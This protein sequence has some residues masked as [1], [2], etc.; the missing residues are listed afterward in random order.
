MR[1]GEVVEMVVS[2]TDIR[3]GRPLP[4]VPASSVQINDAVALCEDAEGGMVF[5]WGMA[6]FSWSAD[7]LCGR[8]L[9]AV[10]LIALGAAKVMEV[11]AGFGAE[12]TTLWRWC[13]AYCEGGVEALAGLPKGPK[14]PSKLTE[15]K[16]A[17][18]VALRAAGKTIAETAEVAGV[19]ARSIASAAVIKGEL[20]PPRAGTST[21]LVVARS[22]QLVPLARPAPRRVE[23]Q[24]ARA[25]LLDG[26]EAVFTDGASV[27]L[28]GVLCI[29]PALA[30]TGIVDAFKAVWPEARAAFYSLTQLVCSFAFATLLGA[31]RAERA[32]RI[33]PTA[34]GRLLGVDRGPTAHTLRRRL[35]DLAGLGRSDKLWAALAAHHLRRDGLPEG[36]VYLDGHVRAYHGNADLAKAHLARMRIA[37]AATEDLWLNDALGKAVLVWT[38]E[39]GSGLV[40]QLRRAVGEVRAEL[41]DEGPMTVVFDRGGWSPATFAQLHREGADILTYRKSP[42]P[43]EPASAFKACEVLDEWGHPETYL[44]SDR[45]VRVYYDKRRHYFSCRQI[46]RLDPRTGHQTQ[47]VTTRRDLGAGQLAQ[48]MFGR[49]GASE[50]FFRYSRARFELDGLDSYAKIADDPTRLVTNPAKRAAAK[51]IKE[52]K[53]SLAQA[54][55][56]QGRAALE[57]IHANEELKTAFA[58]A[59]KHIENLKAESKAIPAKVPLG[60]LHPNGERLDPERKRVCDA[61][62]ISAYNA[63]TTLARMLRPHYK[64]AEDEARTLLRE[65]YT[66]PA[67]MQVVGDR[68]EIRIEPLSAPHRTKALAALCEELTASQT[69][70]PGTSLTLAYSVK[71][72]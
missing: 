20:A 68:L 50:N 29:L 23:R 59:T 70:Y 62:R 66:A 15:E 46:T 41:G 9:A 36:L 10:Q 49:W 11:A 4:L 39:P 35:A 27:P 72:I 53:A 21:S 12:R 26:A 56:R 54:Q 2:V 1:S 69:T 44:L 14:G 58:A 71:Q 18:I 13:Q 5:F 7:D 51:A 22:G 17:E 55:E 3:L 16:V 30:A 48:Y 8:R 37:M 57:G 40:S 38:P 52:A 45:A 28:A 34:M 60:D 61:I 25:G 47:I 65:I 43:A 31:G 64:R 32:G 19:S 63:E 67:D 42:K 24:A 33:D 6:T